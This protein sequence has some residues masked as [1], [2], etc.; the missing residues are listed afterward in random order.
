MGADMSDIV[1]KVENLKKD[2]QMGEVTV[3]ALKDTSF[4][5]KRENLLLF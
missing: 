3:N 1:L 2:Y 4:E 5:V